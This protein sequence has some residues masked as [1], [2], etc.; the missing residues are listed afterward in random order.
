[1]LTNVSS[2]NQNSKCS[3]FQASVLQ[4][5]LF[6]W[7]LVLLLSAT[8]KRNAQSAL[9]PYSESIRWLL[10]R[11]KFQ[12]WWLVIHDGIKSGQYKML[13][14]KKQVVRQYKNPIEPP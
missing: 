10:K 3:S 1:M 6:I 2:Q 9:L 7:S 11:R 8:A 13:T 14:R 12:A 4:P 5:S